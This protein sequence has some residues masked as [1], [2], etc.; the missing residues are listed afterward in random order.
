MMLEDARALTL[1]GV[2][3][4][5]AYAHKIS[6]GIAHRPKVK[7]LAARLMMLGEAGYHL[8]VIKKKHI[9]RRTTPSRTGQ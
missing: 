8:T 4:P 7:L 5:S 3:K 9:L 6:H 2:L 1:L